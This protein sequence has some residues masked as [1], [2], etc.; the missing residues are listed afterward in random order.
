M[1][2][3]RVL[4]CTSP[5][6]ILA[7]RAALITL[8]GDL[9]ESHE[10]HVVFHHPDVPKKTRLSAKLLAS[11]LGFSS[12]T[13]LTELFSRQREDFSFTRAFRLSWRPRQIRSELVTELNEYDQLITNL[14]THLNNRFGHIDVALFRESYSRNDEI[15]YR[16]CGS[17][18]RFFAIED[19][20]ASYTP[21]FWWLREANRHELGVW[22]RSH[23]KSIVA[24]VGSILATQRVS[25]SM[26]RYR[27]SRLGFD[28]SFRVLPGLGYTSTRPVFVSI[29]NHLYK[30][31][32][33]RTNAKVIV[34]GSILDD[35]H[36]Q[37]FDIDSEVDMYNSV[38]EH[39][40]FTH[41]V[42]R[43]E[44]VYFPHPRLPPEKWKIKR[45]R[46]K[47]VVAP[48][49]GTVPCEIELCNPELI[50]VYSVGST[51]L[52]YA[53]QVF[54]AKCVR[55]DLRDRTIHPSRHH[56]YHHLF[57]KLGVP[58]LPIVISY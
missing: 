57:S 43:S 56:L 41:C 24:V 21:N 48:L 12:A 16:A 37:L 55:I 54:R 11:K 14:S 44:I 53:S 52:F 33:P 34:V 22:V 39:I 29:V 32:S 18:T 47:C 36:T 45:D 13:D 10:D 9:S 28:H 2:S 26:A 15:A 25:Q 17:D 27:S 46:M 35:E 31:Q 30:G 20:L 58:E 5:L 7:A 23:L 8:D 42:S 3:T 38:I 40:E 1:P 19:G 51:T 49:D 6:Q 50:A 4:F